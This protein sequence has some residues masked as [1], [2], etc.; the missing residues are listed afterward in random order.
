MLGVETEAVI[1]ALVTSV[2][3]EEKA[4]LTAGAGSGICPRGPNRHARTQGVRWPSGVRG[5]SMTGLTLA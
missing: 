3:I 5:D 1:D 2:T 4:S